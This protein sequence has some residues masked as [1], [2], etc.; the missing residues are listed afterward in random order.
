M[1]LAPGV[2]L[3]PYEITA[4]IG[5]GGM[6]E[7]YRGRDAA[8]N[9]DVAI[10]VLPAA[11][12]SDADGLARFKREA[13]V[14]ASLNHPNIAHVYGFEG[15]TLPDG[16]TVHFLA[17]EMVEGEDLAER[18][19]RGAIP[20]DDAM[21]FAKQIAEGLEE[22][23]ER[24]IIHRDLKPANVKVTP[25][26]KVKILDFGLAKALDAGAASSSADKQL[27]HSPTMSRHM[28]EAGMI[29]GTAA[30]M[31][32]EQARGKT[33]DKRADIWS[34]GVVLF[35]MLTG[36]R[37]F[38]GETVSDTLAAVLREEVPWARLPPGTPPSLVRL[39]RRCLERDPRQRLRDIGDARLALSERDDSRG[40][41]AS[42][43][44]TPPPI[45]KAHRAAPL[46][47]GLAMGALLMGSLDRTLLSTAPA[48][49]PLVSSL[50]HSGKDSFPTASADGRAVAFV[51]VRDGLSRI[52]LKQIA[53]G[54]EVAVTSG[55]ADIYPQFSP[56]G[57]TLLFLR[58]DTPPFSLF[59]VA[60]VGGTAR[61]VTDGVASYVAWSPDG[62]RVALVRASVA[63]AVQDTLVTLNPD[64][65]DERVLARVAEFALGS[66]QWSPDGATVGALTF[67]AAN[68]VARQ[69]IVDF[70]VRDGARRTLYEPGPNSVV[71]AW[72]WSGS[73]AL[74][75]TEAANVFGGGGTG[76][77]RRIDIGGRPPRTL[78]SLQQA[79]SGMAIAG[80]GRVVIDALSP[81]QNLSLVSLAAGSKTDPVTL[82]RGE[83]AD[84]Q[85]AF[86]PDGARVVFS[87][88]REGNVDVWEIE[89]SSG[90][91]R[92]LTTDMGQDWDPGYSPD[93]KQILFSSRRL[94][95]YEIWMA[96]PDGSGARQVTADGFDAENP[97][98]TPDGRWII[99][100][101]A[102]PAQSGIWK[103]RPDGSEGTLLTKGAIN[104][105]EVSPDG[106][107]VSF[108]DSTTASLRVI[109]LADGADV[110]LADFPMVS[111]G[112]GGTAIT[113]GRSR[114]VNASTLA[115][116]DYDTEARATRLVAQD[117]VPGRDTRASRRVLVQGTPDEMPESFGVSPDGRRLVVSSLR[118]R[119]NILAI[120]GLPG[121]TR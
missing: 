95:H 24:G 34:F 38:A 91:L 102:N 94:G 108:L 113:I 77:L 121:V 12:A 59:R 52:W 72:S 70:N 19:R 51:S 84:R 103:I 27:S 74:L 81:T 111:V 54:E 45:G 97:V 2:R 9:R 69:S 117:I 68:G 75:V 109:T 115:W 4:A 17:M 14:L 48:E 66:L 104:N 93:D 90:N 112:L 36:E 20:V 46:L 100:T 16:S 28:T 11:V 47:V 76:T 106:R 44:S 41:H 23:H 63:G 107:W 88:D 30:Y 18:L 96:A 5:A 64:G 56:D 71:G 82:T 89:L 55:P 7:V 83:S 79:A 114:W 37:L 22:A 50:T 61:R 15:A 35:E 43:T 26:G 58:G 49:P 67:L 60:A 32:P 92:R 39:L 10:K 8:L 101:S 62:K 73:K 42:V 40:D 118:N 33:V 120:E 116:L 80:P 105:A 87:S 3:G 86:S 25:D 57:S 13:Q 119:S 21:A 31:S 85:P 110:P 99:Y 78:L 6:G 98:M 53:T 65:G 1:S 29:M